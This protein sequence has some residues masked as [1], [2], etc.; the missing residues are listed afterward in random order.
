M[1][2]HTAPGGA[3]TA[4]GTKPAVSDVKHNDS[5]RKVKA[6]VVQLTPALFD[7][8][9]STDI[10]CEWIR[11]GAEAG[12]EILLLPE[13]S[14]PGYPRGLSFDA[15]IGARSEKSRDDWLD[16]WSN[17][18]VEGS[19]QHQQISAAVREANMMTIVGVTERDEIG[20]S[21]H[22]CILFFGADGT[23]LGKHRKLKPTG[24]ERFIW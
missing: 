7:L 24:L 10:V 8:Q 11:K 15:R 22:C 17:S 1:N 12:C 5:Y 20:G 3:S 14:I 18:W 6:G 9:G 19:K 4:D 21:L 23:L 2:G 13:S 16:F